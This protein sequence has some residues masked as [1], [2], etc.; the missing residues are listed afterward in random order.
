[1]Y[2]DEYDPETAPQAATSAEGVPCATDPPDGIGPPLP[3]T[4]VRP[5]ASVTFLAPANRFFPENFH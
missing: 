5:D 1:M 4:T 2:P 3:N